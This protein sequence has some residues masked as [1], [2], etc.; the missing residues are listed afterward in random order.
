MEFATWEP[1]YE[2]LLA[3]FGFD[4][5]DDERARDR[6]VSWAEPFDLDRLGLDGAS[7]AVV[8]PGPSLAAELPAVN[9]ADRVIAASSAADY[10][11]ASGQ[12]PDLVVTDLDKTPATAASLSRAGTPVAV[13]AH[14]DNLS[15]LDRWL[16]EHDPT[17]VIA[18][19]QAPPDP[20]STTAGSL[21]VTAGH[22]SQTP[23]APHE[24]SS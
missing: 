23:S 14:G 13:H 1:V 18:T 5:A 8:A 7:V 19:T 11:L 24:S 6:L 3:D 9:E 16:P 21:T 15:A 17:A 20:P 2:L 4:R 22:S 10:L 12:R